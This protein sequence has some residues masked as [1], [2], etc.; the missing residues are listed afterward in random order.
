MNTAPVLDTHVWVWWMN[1][2]GRLDTDITSMLDAMSFPERPFLSDVSLWE[3]AMLADKGR[4]ELNQPLGDWLRFASHERVVRVVPVSA[5]IAAE[6]STARVLRDPADR[7]I[8]ATSRVLGAPLLTHDR[9]ILRSR[10][11]ERWPA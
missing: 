7:L 1:G 9:T 2:D 5:A 3:V 11:V 8:V 4:L 10:L 6:M